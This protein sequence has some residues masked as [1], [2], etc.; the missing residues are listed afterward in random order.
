MDF[1][2]LLHIADLTLFCLISLTVIYMTVFTLASLLPKRNFNQ[3][4]KYQNRFIILITSCRNSNV[5]K[6]V[7]SALG[8]S[9]PQR[10]F[11]ITAISDHN[12]EM[13]NFRLAQ[14]PITL[15][16]PNYR[17][18]NKTKYL[19]LA[20]SNLPQFK[21]YDVVVILEA[22]DIIEPDFLE[23]LNHAY[24]NAG[25]K[26]IQAHRIS[27]NRNTPVSQMAAIFEEINNTIF[28]K[29]H[30]RLGLSASLC[31]S[32]MA[33]NFE[34]FKETISDFRSAW[35]DK[36]LESVLMRQ[37]IYIDYVNDLFVYNEKPQQA[38]DFNRQRGQWIR[39]QLSSLLKN[40]HHLPWA[41]ITRQYDLADK[42]I[43]WMLF[44]RLP[45][46]AIIVLM[47]A[48]LP[49]IYMS[50]AMKWWGLF[51]F[52]LFIF[53]LATPDY[54]VDSNW[55]SS[56]LKTPLILMKSIPG[57]SK[58]A[59]LIETIEQKLQNKSHR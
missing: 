19:Q 58:I 50:L 56:S 51:A 37:H 36:N 26:A 55:N 27:S 46:M 16:T 21:I 14:Q 6:T 48:V 59:H 22:G 20:I 12:E 45:L 43:Q 49:F 9:Y 39:S 24:E 42:I 2:T 7:A 25:T 47:S 38:N 4:A 13:T 10:L 18:G 29:G 11:D 33:F 31:A 17:H 54:L 30:N 41:I 15:L 8:Q 35:D 40:I 32:G 23:N 57:L 34:W 28:R 44:P 3:K 1:W 52:V 5:E 53:A